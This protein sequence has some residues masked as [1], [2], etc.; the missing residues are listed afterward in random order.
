ML[1]SEK[2]R[3]SCNNGAKLNRQFGKRKA[4]LIGLRLQQLNALA[5]LAD[6]YTVPQLR[7]H[8]L[9]GD[10]KG[11]FAVDSVNPYRIIFKPANDPLPLLNDGGLDKSKVTAI[12]ILEVNFDYHGQ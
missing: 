8:V 4:D 11:C 3:K 5:T 2:I 12:R 9:S 1:R 7:C 10:W 6:S